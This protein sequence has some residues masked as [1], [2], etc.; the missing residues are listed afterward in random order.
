MASVAQ[1]GLIGLLVVTL[2][3]FAA[4]LR[5]RHDSTKQA[6]GD[7]RDRAVSLADGIVAPHVTEAL[8]AGEPGG[9]RRDGP[10]HPEL[11]GE[12]PGHAA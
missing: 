11:R 8:L 4:A 9:H 3:G 12:G 6:I 2:L 1:F 5:L 7:A 10:D